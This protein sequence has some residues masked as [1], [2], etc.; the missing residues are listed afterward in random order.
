MADVRAL[1]RQQRVARRIEH[2]HAAYSDAGKLM[3]TVCNEHVKTEL[4]WDGHLKSTGHRQ[5]LQTL[6]QESVKKGANGYAG[7]VDETA[8]RDGPAARS[9]KRKLADAE[10]D[11]MAD[12]EPESPRSKRSK[13]NAPSPESPQLETGATPAKKDGGSKS[14]KPTTPPLGRRI[15]GTPTI[16]VE[17]QIPSR[18]ATPSSG[19]TPVVTTP[20]AAPI[21]RSPLIPDALAMPEQQAPAT[22]PSAATADSQPAADTTT[23]ARAEIT[24]DVWAAFEA[25]L[26]H[27]SAAASSAKPS[28]A[29]ALESDAVISA[30]AMSAAELAAKS[31]E[32]ERARRRALVDIQIEDEKEDATRALEDEFDVMEELEARARRL[33]ERR[34]ALRVQS[35]G[36]V[37][38]AAA[39]DGEAK[40]FAPGK[41]NGT[42]EEDEEGDEDDEDDEDDWDSF[43]FR[44]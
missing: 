9:N 25:D 12:H 28:A 40:G 6:H 10:D 29:A 38:P 31:E 13:A 17:M 30:P 44:A 16:G 2:P 15:S 37:A 41:E 34:E 22:A 39:T 20:K 19:G 11:N 42:V 36:G 32:E 24:D 35:N 43:R 8:D 5:R 3:C 1:L 18:P 26:I 33:R 7:F 23:S 4:L 14:G 21:G 27:G